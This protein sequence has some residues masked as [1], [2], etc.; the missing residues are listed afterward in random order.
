MCI[1]IHIL[2]FLL[3]CHMHMHTA[4]QKDLRNKAFFIGMYVRIWKSHLLM[5]L[6]F[7]S[8][9][10]NC[11]ID[12]VSYMNQFIINVFIAKAGLENRAF[13]WACASQPELSLFAE[14][15]RT[16]TQCSSCGQ[17]AAGGSP[18]QSRVQPYDLANPTGGKWETLEWGPLPSCFSAKW[19]PR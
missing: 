3:S 18:Q 15:Q 2:S 1:Y 8:S 4:Q 11:E 6:S 7:Q 13:P 16:W 5:S 10:T 14:R 9:R 12:T 19:L 17:A